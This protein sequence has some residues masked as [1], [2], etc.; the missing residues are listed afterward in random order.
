MRK[1]VLFVSGGIGPDTWDNEIS[2]EAETFLD[3]VKLIK[4]KLAETGDET[5]NVDGLVAEEL[6]D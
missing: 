2:I 4:D 1:W 3:A 6:A 5:A